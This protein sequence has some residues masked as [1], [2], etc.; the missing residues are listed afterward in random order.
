MSKPPK[1]PEELLLAPD[2]LSSDLDT[3][4]KGVRPAWNRFSILDL[5]LLILMSGLCMALMR[6]TA[7]RPSSVPGWFLVPLIGFVCGPFLIGL[8]FRRGRREPLRLGEVVWIIQ[9]VTVFGIYPLCYAI[10]S[11]LWSLQGRNEFWGSLLLLPLAIVSFLAMACF[12]IFEIAL[13]LLCVLG[14]VTFLLPKVD[15]SRVL[16]TEPAGYLFAFTPY[17]FF[18]DGLL[19]MP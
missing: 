17:F 2:S 3:G 7:T 9:L 18:S 11:Q 15:D 10:L 6:A 16:W 1:G 8:Q 4:Q 13:P 14:L 5:C 19:P 12:A